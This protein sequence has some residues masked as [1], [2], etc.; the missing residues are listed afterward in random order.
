MQ[1][2][3][4]SPAEVVPNGALPSVMFVSSRAGRLF[5]SAGPLIVVSSGAT[6]R[7][8]R[9]HVKRPNDAERGR[10]QPLAAFNAP[11]SPEI[12][13]NIRHD[14]LGEMLVAAFKGAWANGKGGRGWRGPE[15]RSEGGR[16]RVART[17]GP[18]QE[19][20]D[21]LHCLLR[22][23]TSNLDDRC[24]RR[25]SARARG[26]PGR[27]RTGGKDMVGWPVHDGAVPSGRGESKES[28]EKERVRVV[29][30]GLAD[31]VE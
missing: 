25:E 7:H 4:S 12:S 31:E 18:L 14:M 24:R 19:K 20:R 11:G 15:N 21:D 13:R 27:V 29:D 6:G 16:S 5:L 1:V 10:Q 17:R 28:R 22:G 3:S 9:A 8:A 26:T 2:A 30:D 23:V